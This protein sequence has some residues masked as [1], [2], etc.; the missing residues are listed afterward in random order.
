MPPLKVCFW[1]SA[2]QA[3]T[4]SLAYALAARED[5]EVVVALQQPGRYR[6]QPVWRLRPFGGRLVARKRPWTRAVLRHFAPDVLVVDNHVPSFR[7]APRVFVLWHGFGWRHDDIS[8]MRKRLLR[9]IGDVTIPTPNFIWQAFG[10]WDREYTIE[11]RGVHPNN[12]RELGSAYSDDLLPN[13]ASRAA[14]RADSVRNAYQIDVVDRPTVLMGLT[15]HHR[16]AFGAWG[17]ERKLLGL[18]F[19]HLR[20]RGANV[21]LRMHDRRRYPREYLSQ[22]RE[23]VLGHDHVQVTFRDQSPDS[24]VDLMVS[25]ALV[26]NYSSLANAF[27][28]TGKPTI[29]IDTSGTPDDYVYRRPHRGAIV[30]EH[31]DAPSGIWKLPPEEHGGLRAR[32]FEELLGQ[33]DHA[34]REPTCCQ[35]RAD[36]FVSKYLTAADGHTCDRMAKVLLEWSG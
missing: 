6:R 11:H 23:T 2:F 18:L 15:W 16:G 9:H 29:H 12:V 36:D 14:F 33:I 10:R 20:Q 35:A 8:D 25:T 30:E 34:L 4:Q 13:S 5:F 21:L 1:T 31:H 27:Y 28:C 19:S 32:S 17:D 24:W 22:L 7:L 26:T 3:D